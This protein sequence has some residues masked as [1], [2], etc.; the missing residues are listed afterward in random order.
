MLILLLFHNSNS[1]HRYV[2]K[3]VK[4]SDRVF[5]SPD[6]K[7]TNL[8]VKNLD[9]E[10]TE[11]LLREKFSKFGRIASLVIAKDDNGASRGFGFVNFDNPDDAKCALEEMNGSELGVLYVFVALIGKGQKFF[12]IIHF[13]SQLF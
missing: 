11:V 6:A 13:L 8:Y 1:W 4:K 3:F 9:S 7:Y 12:N 5:P 10:I 2:G